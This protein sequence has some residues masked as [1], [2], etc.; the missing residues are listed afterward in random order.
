MTTFTRILI[1]VVILGVIAASWGCDPKEKSG[2]LN[3][4]IEKGNLVELTQ[5]LKEDKMFTREEMDLFTSGIARMSNTPDSLIGKTVA[6]VIE[7]Q[8]QTL[9]EATAENMLNSAKRLEMF[10]QH[11]FNYVGYTTS[12]RDTTQLNVLV[13]E[14]FNKSDKEI[15]DINGQLSFY[16]QKNRQLIKQFQLTNQDQKIAP[17]DTVRLQNAFV[18]NPNDQRDLIFRQSKMAAVW[19][20]TT[21][22]FA[23]GETISMNQK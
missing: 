8:R 2:F 11:A 22:T 4:K 19:Q 1:S 13:F 21:I 3:D 17:G 14:I 7:I 16:N 10:M 15:T 12:E 5:K 20:P 23:D 18:H 6:E 9:R